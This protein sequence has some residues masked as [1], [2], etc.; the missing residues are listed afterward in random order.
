M[1]RNTQ[2][3][4]GTSAHGLWYSQAEDINNAIEVIR[5]S[6]GLLCVST[7]FEP[8]RTAVFDVR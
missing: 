1:G 3:E 5:H 2:C 8:V 4:L 7:A 6:C